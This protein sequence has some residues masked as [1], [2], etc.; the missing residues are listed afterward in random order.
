[1]EKELLSIF[2]YWESKLEKHEWYFIDSYESI[3]NDLTSED[4]FNSIP[5]TVSVPL[6]LENSFL[7]GETIDFIHE[8]YNIA[9]ITEIH[10]YLETLI[11]NK[12]K[13]NG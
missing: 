2:K 6:K 7:I 5:E 3:I 1:M 11:N 8:I 4:A 12:R 10:P 13:A 9:D